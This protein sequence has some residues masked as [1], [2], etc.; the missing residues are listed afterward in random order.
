[1]AMNMKFNDL[2][3]AEARAV[4]PGV[5]ERLRSTL[6][7]PATR[8]FLLMALTS[9]CLLQA[10]AGFTAPT[11]TQ[12]AAGSDHT[13]FVESDGS[14]WVVGDNTFGELGLGFTPVAISVPRLLVAGNVTAVAG[15]VD[16]SLFKVGGSLWGMGRNDF[17][18]LGDGT[19]MNHYFPEQIVSSQVTAIAAGNGYS[20]FGEFHPRIGP[21]SLWGT[22]LNHDGVL[23]SSTYVQTNTPQQIFSVLL[24]PAVSA[25]A[26]GGNNYSLFI[27]PD[28]SLWGMG[29]NVFGQLG[30]GTSGEIVSSGVTAIAVGFRHSLFLKSDGGLWGMG[31]DGFGQLGDNSTNDKHSPEQVGINVMAVAAGANHSLFIKSDGSLWGMGR[32]AYGQLGDGTTTNR[33]VPVLIVPSNIVAVA[34]GDNHSLFVKSDGTLWAMGLNTS[35]QLGDGTYSNRYTTVQVVPPAPPQPG[36]TAIGLAGTNLSLAGTNGQSGR[37]CY[38]LTATNLTIPVAQWTLVG[39]NTFSADGDFSFTVTNAANPIASRQFYRLELQN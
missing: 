27:K 22:G 25:V 17:G 1:M 18:Q 5:P 24:S 29:N 20:L 10:V 6:N 15:G 14:L 23:G 28:G 8:V 11:V 26:A 13:L 16:Y 37:I 32:N 33:L 7:P 3:R 21:G 30:D 34:A 36:I 19:Y 39:T 2:L 31:Y 35:G 4:R 12:V 38:T 9:I